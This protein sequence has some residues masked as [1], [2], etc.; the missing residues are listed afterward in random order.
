MDRYVMHLVHLN[1]D[2]RWHLKHDGS[3]IG[4]F[5]TKSEAEGAGVARG[6]KLWEQ[7]TPAQLIVHREDGSIEFEH[8]YGKDPERHPG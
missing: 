7:G 5:D 1:S 6:N 2:G 8:T 3:V 4:S